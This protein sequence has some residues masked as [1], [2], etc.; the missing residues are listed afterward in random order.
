MVFEIESSG[1]KPRF[2]FKRHGEP[3][4]TVVRLEQVL[5][6]RAWRIREIACAS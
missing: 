3:D 4:V 2:A 6:R 1:S 5:S